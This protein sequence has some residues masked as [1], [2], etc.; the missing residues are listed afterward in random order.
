MTADSTL[1]FEEYFNSRSCNSLS[2][3]L[4]VAGSKQQVLYL[5]QQQAQ[6]LQKPLQQL[7]PA[8]ST[9]CNM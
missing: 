6:A 2:S 4:S 7:T 5:S 3:M 9:V 8:T 1:V